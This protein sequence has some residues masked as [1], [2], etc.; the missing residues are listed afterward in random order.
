MNESAHF[1]APDL[2][3]F[4]SSLSVFTFESQIPTF[5]E[6]AGALRGTDEAKFLVQ[7]TICNTQFWRIEI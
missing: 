3:I 1:F 4:F 2:E 5:L 7:R 6:Y